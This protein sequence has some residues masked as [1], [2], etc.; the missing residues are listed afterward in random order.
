MLT[1]I[2]PKL[3]MRHKANTYDFYVDKLGFKDVGAMDF[4][5]Y[6]ILEKDGL[7]IHFFEFKSLDPNENYG[8]IYIRT[9]AIDSLYEYLLNK[10]VNIHPN[11]HLENKPWGQREFSVLDPDYNLLTFGQPL[12]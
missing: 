6:L 12:D 8:Q 10:H 1:A 9:D 2:V 5:H 4:G 7:Q 11:G 3:P